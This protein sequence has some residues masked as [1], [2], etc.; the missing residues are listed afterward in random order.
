MIFLMLMS[1]GG[2]RSSA[3][4]IITPELRARLVTVQENIRRSNEILLSLE[5]KSQ[6]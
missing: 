3:P 5:R 4:P 2:P 1:C 6:Q